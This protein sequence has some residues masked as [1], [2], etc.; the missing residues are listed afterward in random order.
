MEEAA[1]LEEG[2]PQPGTS[3]ENTSVTEVRD[4]MSMHYLHP[5]KYFVSLFCA[6]KNRLQTPSAK[7]PLIISGKRGPYRK[8]II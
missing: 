5:A 2:P 8:I 7:L 1:A 6:C 4:E 3:Q